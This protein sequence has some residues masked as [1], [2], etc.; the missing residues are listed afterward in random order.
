MRGE[1]LL[2]QSCSVTSD[3]GDQVHPGKSTQ[4]GVGA[5]EGVQETV[6]ESELESWVGTALKTS[7]CR[8]ECGQPH[9]E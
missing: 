3:E 6:A 4:L 9:D 2:V 1:T 8:A 5:V 7:V